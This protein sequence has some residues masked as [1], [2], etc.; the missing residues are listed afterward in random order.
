MNRGLGYLPDPTLLAPTDWRASELLGSRPVPSSAD[1]SDLVP[2]I[3]N[4]GALGSCTANAAAYAIR[5]SMLLRGAPSPA[6]PSRL[7]LYYLARSTHGA[8][9]IDSG[10]HLRAVFSVANQFGFPPESEW[11]YTDA[12]EPD[13]RAFKMPS[14]KAFRAAYDQ[15]EP[16][17]YRRIYE[18]GYDRIDAIKRAL[19]QRHLVVYGTDVSRSFQAGMLWYGHEVYGPPVGEPIVGGHAMCLT[20]FNG[21]TFSG[22]NSWGTDWNAGGWY[23]VSADYLAWEKTRDLWIVR[24]APTWGDSLEFTG[25]TGMVA[26]H[27]P[28]R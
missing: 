2:D 14:H 25:P 16:T 20:G 12:S 8:A 1:N 4:Q 10:S 3:L 9:N 13:A 11:D 7:F 18:S 17:E 22:P 23:K 28:D 26:T 5:A 6:F 19:A 27:D 21:D 15:H 24:Y